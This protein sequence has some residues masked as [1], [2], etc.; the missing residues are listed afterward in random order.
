MKRLTKFAIAVALSTSAAY[1]MLPRAAAQNTAATE[2]DQQKTLNGSVLNQD[3]A[4][5]SGA[6]V[7]LKNTKTL[8]VKSFISDNSGGFHFNSLSPNVDYQVYAE[9]NGQRSGTKTVSSFDSKTSLQMT[10]KI[11]VKK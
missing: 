10:L 8:S 11:D 6:V 4:P 7:F 2:K 5:L 9:F 1:V 3:D